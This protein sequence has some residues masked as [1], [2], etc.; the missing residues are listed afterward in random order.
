MS[1]RSVRTCPAR[2]CLVKRDG[3]QY[4]GELVQKCECCCN[5][6]HP[7]Y[8]RGPVY[9][10]WHGLW[11]GVA[12][13]WRCS[14]DAI[15]GMIPALYV[16]VAGLRSFCDAA[17]VESARGGGTARTRGIRGVARDRLPRRRCTAIGPILAARTALRRSEP[18]VVVS[19]CTGIVRANG[20]ARDFPCGWHA[21]WHGC[22]RCRA[23]WIRE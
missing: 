17:C 5:T 22:R 19:A 4:L 11:R 20:V 21:V 13:R 3:R 1:D 6:V 2:T 23:G 9:D 7:A 8:H 12:V 15:H 10:V 18:P 14:A 16:V